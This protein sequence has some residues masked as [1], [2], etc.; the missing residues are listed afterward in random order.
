[1]ITLIIA[2]INRSDY[3]I[4][5]LEC[6]QNQKFD[7]Q[8]LI[9]DSSDDYHLDKIQKYLNKNFFS[10]EVEHHKMPNKLP[11]ECI[12][13]LLNKIKYEYTMWICD[14]DLLVFKTLKKCVDFLKHN[15][16][17]SAAGGKIQNVTIIENNFASCDKYELN[18]FLDD[19][20]FLRLEK[21]SKKYQVVQYSVSRTKDFKLRYNIDKNNFDKS[22]GAEVYPTVFLIVM[23]KIKF[24][25][26]L[27][28]IRQIHERRIILKKV[29]KKINSIGYQA[30]LKISI[31]NI[32]NYIKE[33][34]QEKSEIIDKKIK[35][36]FNKYHNQKIKNEK[37]QNIPKKSFITKYLKLLLNTNYFKFKYTLKKIY[38]NFGFK[39]LKQ[40]NEIEKFLIKK[41]I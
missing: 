38:L 41:V 3:L 26:D 8:L 39:K 6:L 7:G 15:P 18:N 22:L 28:C 19:N 2:S 11:H 34:S 21:F 17:F 40:F 37:L 16:D 13:K 25:D 35:N 10:F 20:I 31:D 32:V 5:Y 12:N 1:M 36:Y 33:K 24:F 23:G 30:S 29:S 27:F 14:D 9:G 4:K